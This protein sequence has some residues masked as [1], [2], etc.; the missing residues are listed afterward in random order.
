MGR[1]NIYDDNF[2]P[3]TPNH[4]ISDQGSGATGYASKIA[5]SFKEFVRD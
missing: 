3:L 4:E 5:Y 1:K 2:R